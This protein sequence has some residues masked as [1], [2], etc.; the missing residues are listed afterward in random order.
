[1]NET[2]LTIVGNLTDD[3]ELRFTPS[4]DA[5]AKFRVASTPRYMDRTT[6]EWK[7]GEPLFLD[8]S[9]WRSQ[10]ENVAETL[11]RGAR[12]VV[13]GVLKQRSYEATD[14]TKRTVMEVTADEV[15]ASLL[16]AKGAMTKVS[17]GGGKGQRGDADW[18]G[19]SK[20]RPEAKKE[21]STPAPEGDFANL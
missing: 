3:P 9:V 17:G 16:Y 18:E 11:T 20:T 21:E 14:G 2:R 13:S 8:V 1:M 4:G 7:D 12:V 15:G 19:A 10:A 6:Q 5:V